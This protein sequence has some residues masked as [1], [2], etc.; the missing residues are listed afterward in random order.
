MTLALLAVAGA[1]VCSGSAAVLQAS[2]VSRLPQADSMS[3]GFVGRLARS[4]RYLLALVLVAAGFGLSI[5][6][7]RTLPLFVVQA[8]RA[9][10][11]AITAVLS[12][13]LLRVRLRTAEV[14]AVI[15]IGVGLVV[16]AATAGPQ[17]T[18]EVGTAVRVGMLVAVLLIA[19]TAAA[20]LRIGNPAHAGLVQAVL[21][22]LFT[23]PAAW[24][25]AGAGGLGLLLGAMAL[26]RAGV[27]TVT[28]AMVAT[29]T[30]VGAALGMIICDDRPAPGLA[31]AAIGGCL[32]VLAGA[33]VLARFG[34]PAPDARGHEE[35]AALPIA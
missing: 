32:L 11:L 17:S 30:V 5:L 35:P 13:L 10:S 7:L 27:V 31:V 24:A 20:A 3:A 4:P 16:V 12:V 23:A 2:A 9:S 29:E 22:G 1:A 33:L 25:M 15:G 18:A 19:L 8:G 14:I 6:A 28:S 26:Q 21:A 34:A